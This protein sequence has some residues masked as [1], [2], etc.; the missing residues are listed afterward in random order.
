MRKSARNAA[1]DV[2]MQWQKS[3][4]FLDVILE[5]QAKQAGLDPRDTAFVQ[6]ITSGVLQHRALLDFY[7]GHYSTVPLAKIERRVLDI[8]RLSAYQILFLDKIPHSA[9][10]DEGVNLT[11]AQNPKAAGFVN[12]VLRRISEHKAHLPQI[13]DADK[14]SYLSIKYSHPKWLVARLLSHLGEAQ[15]EA[16]LSAN[17][18]EPPIFLQVNTLK[19]DSETLIAMLE[20]EEIPV[21]P[22]LHLDDCLLLTHA[23]NITKIEAFQKG[24]FY[25]QDPAARLAIEAFDPTANSR[26]LDACSAPGGK[27]FAAAR[28]MGNLG[29]I[30]ASDIGKGKLTKIEEGAARLGISILTT[31]H[32]DAKTLDPSEMGYFDSVIVDAPCSGLG[33]IRKK[34]EIRYKEEAEIA[35]L[36]EIQR[37]ILKGGARCVKP[38]GTLLYATCTILPEENEAVVEAFLAEHQEFSRVPFTLPGEIGTVTEGYI[39]LYP[40]IHGTDGFFMAKLQKMGNR[41]E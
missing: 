36:P 15:T 33:I 18:T 20:A 29:E 31:R 2:L 8:L 27:S 4:G 19:T 17:N 21:Q 3:G 7:I 34:P 40:H 6:K 12:A 37:E 13:P 30:I 38:G 32:M 1:L 28:K 26:V 14:L 35:A 41:N 11:K 5:K 22:H 24:Y 39:T 16:L 25:I 23:G 9:A 10:V